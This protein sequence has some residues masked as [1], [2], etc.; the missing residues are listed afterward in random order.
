M[1]VWILTWKESSCSESGELSVTFKNC[2]VFPL[3]KFTTHYFWTQ[4]DVT[5]S[6]HRNAENL[7]AFI[8]RNRS[9]H[10][11][12]IRIAT[13]AWIC[14]I[15]APCFLQSLAP[16]LVSLNVQISFRAAV[17]D[18]FHIQGPLFQLHISCAPS[19]CM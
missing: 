13:K 15:S 8:N 4:N 9:K 18:L 3:I 14:F 5:D 7:N 6:T 12:Q 16:V 2:L 19:A 17:P 10:L 1:N 11:L